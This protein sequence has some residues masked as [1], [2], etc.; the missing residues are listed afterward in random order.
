MISVHNADDAAVSDVLFENITVEHEEV[1]S[2]DGSEMPY[3]IDINI[4]ESSNWSSTK[5]RGTV[6]GVTLRNVR[7]LSGNEAGS[8][9]AGYD[10][11]HKAEN[12]VFEDL[13]MFGKKIKSAE[14][15]KLEIKEGTAGEIIW[16]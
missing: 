1:G 13:Y 6:N 4:A 2:G 5:E 7:F 9:I 12:I 14:E 15:G 8:R 10:A 16:K 3:L 11:V